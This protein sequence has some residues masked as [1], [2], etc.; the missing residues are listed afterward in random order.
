MSASTVAITAI[1]YWITQKWLLPT[2]G[3]YEGSM[4]VVAYHPLSRKE[5]RAIM[6]SIVVAAIYVALILWLTFSSYGILRC[7]WWFD[8]FAFIAGILFLLSLGQ[9]LREWLMDS[10]PDGIALTMM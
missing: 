3:K 5:R 9:V 8:A 7:E 6:I 4:K 2:L 10:V 1:V